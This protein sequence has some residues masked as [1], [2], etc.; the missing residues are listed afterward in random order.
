MEVVCSAEAVSLEA[1]RRLHGCCG[2]VK[3][4]NSVAAELGNGVTLGAGEILLGRRKQIG[5]HRF[6]S[7][8]RRIITHH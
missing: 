8:D 3:Q 7:K 4:E 2:T 6:R 1:L 5:R